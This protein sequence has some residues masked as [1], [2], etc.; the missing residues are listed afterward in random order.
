[1]RKKRVIFVDDDQN[2]L[3]GIQNALRRQ[4]HR[5]E[6]V[7]APGGAAAL[8]EME[9][10]PA[11]VI[12]TDMRMPIMD[13]AA[14]LH[15]VRERYP[16]TARI[17][18]SGHAERESVLRALPVAH[19]Y[20]SKPCNGETLVRVIER[21]CQVQEVL[22]DRQVKELVGKLD[23]LPPPPRAYLEIQQAMT[24]PDARPAEVAAIVERDPAMATKVLELVNSAYFGLARNVTAIGDA[25]TYL[26]V[27]ILKALALSAHV[28]TALERSA[29]EGFRLEE[30]QRSS[31]LVACLAKRFRVDAK[32][33][34]TAFTAAIVHDVGKIVLAIGLEERFAETVRLARESRRPFHVVEQ[35]RFGKTHAQV[36][37][38]LLGAW[39][40]P[41]SIIE[42]V[43]YHHTP[44]LAPEGCDRALLAAVHVAD[45]L[46]D[47][48]GGGHQGCSGDEAPDRAFLAH[49]G[50]LEELARWRALAEAEGVGPA[51]SSP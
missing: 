25:V 24:G 33:G 31:L 23:K 14:L 51:P 15:E 40:L 35:E 6:M 30:I 27:E 17:V 29:I 13:G 48:S 42:A 47:C 11:D 50:L 43:A 38:Y 16:A 3:A 49:A 21:T 7:F 46:V 32:A 2:V 19:Q 28:F 9:R 22:F 20:L 4:R 18:L 8:M 12:V 5:W 37:A 26:G 39:G 45:A 34:D 36:G 1:M 41:F 10:A 44:G